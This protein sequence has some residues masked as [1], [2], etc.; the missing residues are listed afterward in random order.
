MFWK[1]HY[2]KGYWERG[3]QHGDGELCKNGIIKKGK[4]ENNNM[5]T[6]NRSNSMW[7]SGESNFKLSNKLN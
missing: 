2:Y 5:L 3:M 1:D 7:E 6:N 4:F